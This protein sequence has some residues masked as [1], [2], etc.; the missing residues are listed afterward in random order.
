MKRYQ[1][2]DPRATEPGDHPINAERHGVWRI[3]LI[4]TSAAVAIMAVIW[5]IVAF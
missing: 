3:A 2:Q 4:S 1:P 5:L